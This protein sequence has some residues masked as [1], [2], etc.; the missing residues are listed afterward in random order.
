[1]KPIAIYTKEE[2]AE[3]LKISQT[4]LDRLVVRGRIN[5]TKVGRRRMFTEAHIKQLIKEG[6]A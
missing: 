6:E 1:M 2:T 4:T 3:M 5:S